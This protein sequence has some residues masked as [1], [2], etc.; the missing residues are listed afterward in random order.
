MSTTYARLASRRWDAGLFGAG[1]RYAV[2]S[3]KG[4]G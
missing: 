3:E 1:P 4:C 2:I